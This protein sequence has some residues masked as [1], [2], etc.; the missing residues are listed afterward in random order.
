[1]HAAT[2]QY[3]QIMDDPY[4]YRPQGYMTVSIAVVNNEAQ[5]DAEFSDDQK[6]AY[7]SNLKLPLTNDRVSV[8]YVT[9]EQ[10]FFRADGTQYIMP[11]DDALAQFL[12]LDRKSVV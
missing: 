8:E 12:N 6:Y 1:M 9:L 2:N 3:K 11:E 7:W 10:N 5:G 4:R